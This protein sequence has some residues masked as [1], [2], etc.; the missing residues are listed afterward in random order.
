ME[1]NKK[2]AF[3]GEAFMDILKKNKRFLFIIFIVS[4]CVRIILS[5][6]P[7]IIQVYPDELRYLGIARS[8]SQGQGIK[9]HNYPDDFQKIL[10]S[11]IILPA[12]FVK[13]TLSQIRIVGWINCIV[14]SS[15]VYPSFC[16]AYK[17]LGDEKWAKFIAIFTITIPT[18]VSTLFFMSEVVF[19]PL[20]LWSIYIV[21]CIFDEKDIRQRLKLNVLG[22]ILFYLTYLNKEMALYLL[23]SYIVVRLVC[24]VAYKSPWKKMI[25]E[26]TV[27]T[28]T[29]IVCF[30]ILKFSLFHGLGN[31]YKSYH[32]M[33]IE[34]ILSKKGALYLI[35]GFVYDIL[36]T[37]LAFGI[38]PILIPTVLIKKKDAVASQFTVFLLLSIL[39]GCAAIA[40]T[41]TVREDFGLRSP[42][43]HIR[44]IAPLVIPFFVMLLYY[45]RQ[46]EIE[47]T[48]KRKVFIITGLFL[49]IF[50]SVAFD[51]RLG[52][53]VDCPSLAYYKFVTGSRMQLL[54]PVLVLKLCICAFTL[55][56]LYL[57]KK[58][59][60][61][62][63]WF[64]ILFTALNLINNNIVYQ[65]AIKSYKITNQTVEQIQQMN[66][67]LHDLNG[68]ILLITGKGFGE[69]NRLFDT[70]ISRELYSTDCTL[71]EEYLDD[72]YVDLNTEPLW[73]EFPNVRYEDLKQVHYIVAT[74]EI[75]LDKKALERLDGSPLDGYIL[76]RNLNLNR[77]YIDR[78][79]WEKYRK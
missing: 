72:G 19:L 49:S 60:K 67:V 34:A 55:I 11:F 13:S 64:A 66:Q 62:I 78:L 63:L 44:Y 7:K 30:A 4:V 17:V 27:F 9:L 33:E 45:M 22:G 76:Y 10:Y 58:R 16:L 48:D 59:K 3:R 53:H 14:M 74:E 31:S 71:F 38:F 37:I 5:D 23:L 24:A 73:V 69:D 15:A 39:I 21:Y 56:S 52:S 18:M 68:N 40:Y 75:P 46:K 61:F 1:D 20:S 36:F 70:Y 26:V 42:R 51:I 29:F 50:I 25:L 8:L 57:M 54:Q 65:Y 43:Q 41:I 77:I 79:K 6:F 35:Y 2:T 28:I 32:V 12:F 47:K